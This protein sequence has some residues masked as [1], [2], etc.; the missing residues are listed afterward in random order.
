[1]MKWALVGGVAL[2]LVLAG[3]WYLYSPA[4]GEPGEDEEP[5]V[6]LWHCPNCGLEMTCPPG[7]EDRVTMCPRCSHEK[8]ALEVVT[9]RPG[10]GGLPLGVNGHLLAVGGGIVA[11]LGLG[12]WLGSRV[13]HGSRAPGGSRPNAGA[14]DAA[15][16]WREELTR[17]QEQM[18]RKRRRRR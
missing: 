7:Q 8:V 15:G 17:W 10:R 13:R 4:G 14:S 1:M 5:E 11:V 6:H 18:A 9:R 16:G 3:C 2:V 12:V